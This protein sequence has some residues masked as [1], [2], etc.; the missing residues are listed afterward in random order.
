MDN[1][2]LRKKHFAVLMEK[3][4][5][6][7]NAWSVRELL[8]LILR[9]AEIGIKLADLEWS[10]LAEN[11]LFDTI[12]IIQVQEYQAEEESRISNEFLQLREKYR[13]PENAEI[14]LSSPIYPILVKF[15][16]E[17]KLADSEI[18][19]IERDGFLETTKLI[20]NIQEFRE[21][22]IKYEA[23]NYI[24]EFSDIL[25]A[26][27]KKLD[28][29][30][31]LNDFEENWL[32]DSNLE[33]TLQ[34][35]WQQLEFTKLRKK[36]QVTG[37]LDTSVSSPLFL[38]LKKFEKEEELQD[39]ECDWLEQ[40]NLVE[41]LDI[42]KKRKDSRFFAELKHEYKA[43]DYQDTD[44]S[45]P[46]YEI[47]RKLKC[48]ERKNSPDNLNIQLLEEDIDWLEQQNLAETVEIARKIHF[49]DL[50]DKYRLVDPRLSFEPFYEIM[51]KLEREERLDPKQVVQ[52]MEEGQLSRNGKI[53]IAHYRLEAIFYEKEYNRTGNK[54]NLASA[55]SNWR[56]ANESQ[57][58]LEVTGQV[59]LSTIRELDLKSAL[60][61]TRGAAFRDL[62]Q[63]DEAENCATQ[64]KE[65]QPNSHQP[66]TLLGAI[67]YDLYK[68]TDGDRWFEMA[69]ERGAND[70]DDEIE[71]IV[72]MTKDKEKRREVAEYLFHK[73]P[74]RYAWANSYIK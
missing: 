25:Y 46:L 15:D 41:L 31:E 10:W 68:Y 52:L 38:I 3:Y 73:D 1:N 30:E 4:R 37:D 63:L 50:K 9:K 2:E 48:I 64:A 40:H 56:K 55:S 33:N 57:K 39:N 43:T 7:P 13:I 24:N 27:L 47:L 16:T 28:V 42:D 17:K 59:N 65:C 60:L 72:R 58:A 51:L 22:V 8:H 35:Y 26:I 36:Y 29:R 69:K 44:P 6:N 62:R 32:L 12:T 34:I 14:S 20:R 67:C 5:V 61:V 21:L 70:T 53:A 11:N 66:Y 74:E 54:R 45:N 23:N 71:R 19:I 18:E 49:S